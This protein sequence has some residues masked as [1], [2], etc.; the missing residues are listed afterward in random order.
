VKETGEWT[1]HVELGKWADAFILAPVTANTLA[2]LA[3][4]YCDNLLIATYLSADCPIFFAPAMD[5]DMYTHPT[6]S[7]RLARFLVAARPTW[8][9]E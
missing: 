5:L 2:K 6:T 7:A 1:N 9:G 4:G 3:N 8:S